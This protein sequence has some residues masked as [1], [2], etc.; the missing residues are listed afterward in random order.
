MLIHARNFLA[1]HL[2]EAT[3][4]IRFFIGKALWNRYVYLHKQIAAASSL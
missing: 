1:T 3:Q 2:S 4:H